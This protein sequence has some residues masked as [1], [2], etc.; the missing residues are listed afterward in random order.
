MCGTRSLI[1]VYYHDTFE[2]NIRQE[3]EEEDTLAIYRKTRHTSSERCCRHQP[4]RRASVLTI[5]KLYRSERKEL[6]DAIARRDIYTCERCWP[7]VLCYISFEN[8]V[9]QEENT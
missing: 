7:A 1:L 4:F 8:D 3:E 2:D 5:N 9:I 6:E